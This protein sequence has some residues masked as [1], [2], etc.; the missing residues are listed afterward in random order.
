MSYARKTKASYIDLAPEDIFARK[1]QNKILNIVWF[2]KKDTQ[3][4]ST[5][6][7]CAH[8]R[9]SIISNDFISNLAQS[10]SIYLFY[11]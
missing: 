9:L 4:K 11:M 7:D 10:A 3:L 5:R 8:S 6:N 1:K 2:V